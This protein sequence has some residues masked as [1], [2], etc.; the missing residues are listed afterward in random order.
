[1]FATAYLSTL[2]RMLP[3][4]AAAG[5]GSLIAFWFSGVAILATPAIWLA[6]LATFLLSAL[7]FTPLALHRR[8]LATRQV[9]S[10]KLR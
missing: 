10:K 3:L 9:R 2:R 7:M 1:M 5:A 8:Q 4:F 6:L